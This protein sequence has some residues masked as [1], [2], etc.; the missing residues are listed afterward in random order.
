MKPLK[1]ILS[2][3]IILCL[4]SCVGQKQL[5]I[6]EMLKKYNSI[7]ASELKSSMFAVSKSNELFVYKR[8]EN[9]V[10]IC[11]YAGNDGEI[12][13]CTVT[14]KSTEKE[15]FEKICVEL[16]ETFTDFSAEKSR[17]LFEHGGVSG[18]FKLTVNNYDIGKTMILN[19]TGNELN[20]NE[21]PTLKRE[22]KEEDIAR[23]T[24]SDTDK[25]TNVIR[26]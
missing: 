3:L 19:K 18:K 11:L 4:T 21:L 16:T 1:I 24:L 13:Q 8:I 22:V 15:A 14:A 6:D 25:T 20:T 5:N 17:K 12:I 10:L 23:P 9:G 2:V 26:Q 7:S